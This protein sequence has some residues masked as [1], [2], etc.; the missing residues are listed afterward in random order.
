VKGEAPVEDELDVIAVDREELKLLSAA[1][2]L[3][4]RGGDVRDPSLDQ[5]ARLLVT[6]GQCI[7]SDRFVYVDGRKD[8]TRDQWQTLVHVTHAATFAARLAASIGPDAQEHVDGWRT[9]VVWTLKH[10]L[11]NA[12]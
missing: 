8:L 4:E 2:E 6:A 7:G 1:L 9:D 11:G 5:V 12:T 10:L 3:L